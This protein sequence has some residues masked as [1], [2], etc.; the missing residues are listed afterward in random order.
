MAEVVIRDIPE[1]VLARL[2]AKAEVK[3]HSLEQELRE[4]LARAAPPQLSPEEK[5]ALAD[6][7]AAMQPK[8][9]EQESWELIRE[10]RDSR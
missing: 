4:I 10:D 1:D 7:I 5:V 2:K 6:R 3:G 8:P 9:L